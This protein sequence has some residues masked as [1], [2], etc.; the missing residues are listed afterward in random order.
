M[1]V[2]EIISRQVKVCITHKWWTLYICDGHWTILEQEKAK[3]LCAEAVKQINQMQ[4]AEL[5]SDGKRFLYRKNAPFG[6]IFIVAD[7]YMGFQLMA[8]VLLY[9]IYI[10]PGYV[11]ASV[12][13]L[14]INIMPTKS[15][16]RAVRDMFRVML[17]C[18]IYEKFFLA[19]P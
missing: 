10:S 8:T 4:S 11:R 19:C 9:R 18:A 5:Y 6:M 14:T 1:Y 13:V 3:P 12:V 16:E 2:Q 7:D 17:R 15:P